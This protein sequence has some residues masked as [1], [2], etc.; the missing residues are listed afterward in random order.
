M[1]VVTADDVPVFYVACSVL[2]SRF[3]YG[4]RRSM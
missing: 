1:H 3:R 2:A 4:L